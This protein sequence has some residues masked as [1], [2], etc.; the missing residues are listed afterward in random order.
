MKK[1]YIII[2]IIVLLIV[3]G[4]FYWY[5][6]MPLKIKQ[7]CSSEAQS[8]EATYATERSGRSGLVFNPF[9]T[10]YNDCLMRFGVK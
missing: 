6:Y 5:A 10:Y 1:N 4:V 7:Q 2:T 9:T 8:R 3:G